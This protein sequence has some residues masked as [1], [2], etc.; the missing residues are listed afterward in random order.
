MIE[1]IILDTTKRMDLAISHC[2]VELSKVIGYKAAYYMY[3][4]GANIEAGKW[5]NAHHALSEGYG[6]I[7]SL[8]YT[9]KADGTPY[10]DNATVNALLAE[11]DKGDGFWDHTKAT[12]GALGKQISDASE[13]WDD[14]KALRIRKF[15]FKTDVAT[16]DSDEHWRLGVIAQEVEAS[17][18]KKLITEELKDNEFFSF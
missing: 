3:S 10:M 1:D 13:Q 6:F 14:I 12:L 5:A 9:Q 18:M 16:G 17:G 11:L 2:K 7:L 4:G 8:Q 15:K